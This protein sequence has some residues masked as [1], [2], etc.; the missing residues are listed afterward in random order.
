MLEKSTSYALDNKVRAFRVPVTDSNGV[1][2]YYDLTIYL[3][4]GSL[5]TINPA[6]TAVATPSPSITTGV[7][8]P[9]T[10]KAADGT[11]CVVTNITLPNGRIQ[12]FFSCLDNGLTT[13]PHQLS[14]A[15]GPVTAGHPFLP[16]LVAAGID[17]LS[18]VTDYT[19]GVT[20]NGTFT[21]GT[22]GN[23]PLGYPVGAQTNGSQLIVSIFNYFKPGA[24][25]CS[26]TFTKQ[27]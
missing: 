25:R 16:T 21:V 11:T 22:C 19:W 10:Y 17:V 1:V 14:V 6:A 9:G 18:N 7:I 27:P 26:A 15:T 23:F 5:G 4:V 24:F 13:A 2:K 8:V 20:T 3:G 12:S